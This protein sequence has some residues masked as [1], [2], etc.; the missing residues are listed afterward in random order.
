MLN[1]VVWNGIVFDVLTVL[2][3]N[4]IAWNRTDLRFNC[5]LAKIILKLN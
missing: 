3:L 4:W 1:R 5:V 2:T